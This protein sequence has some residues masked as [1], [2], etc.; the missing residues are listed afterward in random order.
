[1]S[2]CG[3]MEFHTYNKK[4]LNP[5]LLRSDTLLSVSTKLSHT[6]QNCKGL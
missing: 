2:T 5:H 4:Q 3:D 1:M 6:D